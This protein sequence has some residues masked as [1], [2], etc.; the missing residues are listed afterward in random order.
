MQTEQMIVTLVRIMSESY[1]RA[2]RSQFL[3]I[4]QFVN[5]QM[6][7]KTLHSGMCLQM[8]HSCS[9]WQRN[10][11]ILHMNKHKSNKNTHVQNRVL[12]TDTC[13][14]RECKNVFSASTPRSYKSLLTIVCFWVWI[15]ISAAETR[16]GAR[17]TRR[18]WFVHFLICAKRTM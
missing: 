11:L 7:D 1:V 16:N 17:H 13:F 6:E 9:F 5:V 15:V 4:V 3:S 8:L 2:L 14:V 18:F 10:F 12:T